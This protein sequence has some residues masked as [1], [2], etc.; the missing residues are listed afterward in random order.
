[1]LF[2]STAWPLALA[3]RAEAIERV[4]LRYTN[5]FAVRWKPGMAPGEAADKLG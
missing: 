4:D 2:R 1:M 5:G 3:A